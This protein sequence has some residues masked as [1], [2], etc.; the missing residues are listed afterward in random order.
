[1]NDRLYQVYVRMRRKG[2][3]R[4]PNHWGAGDLPILLG[5][6]A[7]HA[8]ANAM[9]GKRDMPKVVETRA[10]WDDANATPDTEPE[11]EPADHEADESV[12][13]DPIPEKEPPC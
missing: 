12:L 9:L 2:R 3:K 6:V 5:N 8:L 1:M 13:Q 11:P 10:L 4:R 7:A